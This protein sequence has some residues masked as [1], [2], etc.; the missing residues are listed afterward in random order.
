MRAGRVPAL[1]P[2]YKEQACCCIQY[3]SPSSLDKL[4]YT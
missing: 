2:V 3:L 4:L 1:V